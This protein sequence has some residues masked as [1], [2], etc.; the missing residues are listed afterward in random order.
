MKLSQFIKNV[1]NGFLE[2][3]FFSRIF[4]SVR[5]KHNKIMYEQGRFD[6]KMEDL[7]KESIDSLPDFNEKKYKK[8]INVAMEL[9]YCGKLPKKNLIDFE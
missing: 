9:K 2:W 5:L 8:E 4:D 7:L 6:S 3:I 1:Y